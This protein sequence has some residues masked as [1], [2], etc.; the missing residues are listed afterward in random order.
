MIPEKGEE[1]GAFVLT[2]KRDGQKY[3]M[4][5]K[6]FKE[7]LAKLG[8]EHFDKHFTGEWV[9]LNEEEKKLAEEIRGKY[10]AA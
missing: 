3:V 8:E 6:T 4:S 5:E 1:P 9:V 10:F 7:V 2:S